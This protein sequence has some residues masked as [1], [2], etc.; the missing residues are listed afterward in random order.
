MR[1]NKF[2]CLQSYRLK[3]RM[4]VVWPS[5]IDLSSIMTSLWIKDPRTFVSHTVPP[6]EAL[7]HCILHLAKRILDLLRM[8]AKP[9]SIK[10]KTSGR[11]RTPNIKIT[12]FHTEANLVSLSSEEKT[13]QQARCKWLRLKRILRPNMVELAFRSS[14]PR[15]QLEILP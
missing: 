5:H 9:S 8:V 12:G 4:L 2:I 15:L 3:G 11:T 6:E 14:C 1:T 13:I 7:A 10:C